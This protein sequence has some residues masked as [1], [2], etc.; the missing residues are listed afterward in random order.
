MVTVHISVRSIGWDF[1]IPKGG[2]SFVCLDTKQDLKGSTYARNCFSVIL[3]STI[4]PGM[5]RLSYFK[6]EKKGLQEEVV[7]F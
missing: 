3:T 6:E 2:V 1:Y 7:F 5:L 4:Y